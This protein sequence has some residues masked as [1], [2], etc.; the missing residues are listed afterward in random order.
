MYIKKVIIE[1]CRMSPMLIIFIPLIVSGLF[2]EKIWFL[3][4]LGS[5]IN[6]IINGILKLTSNK[7]F[8]NHSFTYRPPNA[9]QCS[10]FIICNANKPSTPIGMPSG[11]SQSIGFL[12]G[13]IIYRKLYKNQKNKSLITRIKEN[14][15]VVF[16]CTILLFTI[17]YS[18]LQNNILSAD[19]NG[20]HTLLQTIVG[21]SIGIFLGFNYHKLIDK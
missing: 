16:A 18:R 11:H 3:F 13:F 4:A 15:L 20:C 6:V 12:V 21:A 7:I 19:I 10:D 9:T 5:I 14:K 1:L 17:M 8:K 2:Q